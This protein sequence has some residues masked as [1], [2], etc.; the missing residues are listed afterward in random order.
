MAER[1]QELD[2]AGQ[3]T[4]AARMAA[5]RAA[6]SITEL[7]DVRHL[8]D[9]STLF[10]R[11]W[12]RDEPLIDSTLLRALSH[13]G[14]YVAA[15]FSGGRMV[16]AIVGFLGTRSGEPELHSHILGVLQEA[17]G[18]DVGFALKQHQRAWA[19]TRGITSVTWTFDP[20]VRRNAYFN[21][22]KLGAEIMQYY[23]DF[24]G[25]MG[26]G[27]NGS[28]DSDRVLA[29]WRLD[30][31]TAVAA[32]RREAVAPNVEGDVGVVLAPDESGAPVV[33][34]AVGSRVLAWIPE[35][36]VEMRSSRPE[37][38]RSWRLGVRASA[39]EALADGYVA[40]GITRDG[41]LL[42]ERRAAR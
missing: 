16:G 41:W 14:N 35:D 13:A 33:R 7:S 28:D 11:V 26:D 39:G 1:L 38:A 30:S 5:D 32:S 12:S 24:Y 31:P 23:V 34:K 18:K 22:V 6:V 3:A 29:R 4:K 10:R 9:A 36:I 21:L 42:L 40:T 15:A 17:R 20:L 8:E 19:L 27:I 25:A 37:M 2:V